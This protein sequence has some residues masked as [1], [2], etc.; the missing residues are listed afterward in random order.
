VISALIV[1]LRAVS[2]AVIC[3]LAACSSLDSTQELQPSAISSGAV[4][5]QL[6]LQPPGQAGPTADLLAGEVPLLSARRTDEWFPDGNPIWKVELHRGQR[7]L[8]SWDAA[9]GASQ[10]QHADRRWSPGNA[11]PLPIGIYALGQPEPW[12]HDLWFDLQPRFETTRSALGIHRCFPGTGCICIPDRSDI[13]ALAAWVRR[14]RIQQL[15][16]LN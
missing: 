11:S 1:L 4:A 13:D 7:L 8:A 9:S 5:A 2:L 12:G 10:R 14:A 3:F 15:T 16:V 6:P